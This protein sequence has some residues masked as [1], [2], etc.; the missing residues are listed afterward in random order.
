V[1]GGYTVD[2]SVPWSALNNG[3]G[4]QLGKTI[5]FDLAVD[6]DVNGGIR[7]A[8]LMWVGT[9]QA[10]TNTSFYDSLVLN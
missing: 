1:T 3:L 8:Q 10:F 6:D 5:G 9:D 2:V 4:S 7:D